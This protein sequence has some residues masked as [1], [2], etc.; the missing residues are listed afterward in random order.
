MT[1]GPES[2]RSAFFGSPLMTDD[3]LV[4]LTSGPG[5]LFGSMIVFPVTL[6]QLRLIFV[7]SL[8]SREQ[9]I[10]TRASRFL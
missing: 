3:P 5:V 7:R 6:C 1:I 9:R 8:G 10:T 4:I 2:F